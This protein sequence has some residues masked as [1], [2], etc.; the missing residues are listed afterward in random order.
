MNSDEMILQ[1]Y[2]DLVAVEEKLEVKEDKPLGDALVSICYNTEKKSVDANV[3]Q[4]R[5]LPA[6]DQIGKQVLDPAQ[7]TGASVSWYTSMI[8]FCQN[9][10]R[11]RRHTVV[12]CITGCIAQ[13]QTSLTGVNNG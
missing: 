4:A 5:G 3:V 1:F 12:T 13:T 11:V 10:C 9:M 2:S 6:K 7:H 8:S